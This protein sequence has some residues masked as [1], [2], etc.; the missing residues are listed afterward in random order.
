MC[1][2]SPGRC[3]VGEKNQHNRRPRGASMWRCGIGQNTPIVVDGK[4]VM[5]DVNRV[6]GAHEDVQ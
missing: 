5:P 1:A 3:F 2:G 6:A 4:D